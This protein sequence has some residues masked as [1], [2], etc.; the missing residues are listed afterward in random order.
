MLVIPLR[1]TEALPAPDTFAALNEPPSTPSSSRSGSV[2][3]DSGVGLRRSSRNR[4]FSRSRSVSQAP[5]LKEED[6]KSAGSHSAASPGLSTKVRNYPVPAPFEGAAP[7]YGSHTRNYDRDV[8][9]VWDAVAG[10]RR[11]VVVCGAGISV[12]SPANI[13]DFRS[14]TGLFRKLKEKHPNAGLSSGKD[15]FD[16]RLFGSEATSALFY[17]MIHELKQLADAAK[18]TSFH[19]LLKRLDVEGRLMRVYTQNID[20]LEERAGLSFGLGET[21][22]STA[23]IRALGKRKREEQK[24]LSSLQGVSTEPRLPKGRGA[25]GR[26]VSDSALLRSRAQEQSDEPV[27]MF[28]RTIPLHG[29]LSSLS[30]SICPHEL[31]LTAPTEHSTSRQASPTSEQ[32]TER[33]RALKLLAGGEPVPC[34]RCEDYENVRAVAGLRSRGVGRMKVGVVLYGGQNEGAEQV[35]E[36]LQRDILG[37]RDPHETPVPE[38]VSERRARQRK[39]AKMQGHTGPKNDPLAS[40]ASTTLEPIVEI[41]GEDALAAAFAE[42]DSAAG[43][44]PSMAVPDPP[45]TAP[46]TPSLQAGSKKRA[47]APRLKP[48]PPDLLIVAG[49]SL[50]VPGTKRI[51]REFAKACRARDHRVYNDS[52]EEESGSGSSGS[53]SR[54]SSSSPGDDEE[55]HD[56]NAPIRTILLNYD[57]PGPSREWEDIFDVWVQGD[58]QQAALGLWEASTYPTTEQHTISMAPGSAEPDLAQHSWAGLREYLESERKRDRLEKRQEAK[59]KASSNAADGEQSVQTS[60]PRRVSKAQQAKAKVSASAVKSAPVD[61]MCASAAQIL[62]VAIEQK[63]KLKKAR[64]DGPG[65][66]DAASDEKARANPTKTRKAHTQARMCHSPTASSE[67]SSAEL[68]GQSKGSSRRAFARSS[69]N[70]TAGAAMAGTTRKRRSKSISQAATKPITASFVGTKPKMSTVQGKKGGK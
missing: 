61:A 7:S 52:D 19:H 57:F 58:V 48:L 36:C 3:A 31:A 42:D 10:A 70:P 8:A 69:S 67:T 45:S 51:V 38:S 13:P 53:D 28:P 46:Q 12:S 63:I 66:G 56:P 15:L 35:G 60:S 22:D 9:R 17:S 59:A 27:P 23:T 50:K 1:P 16:A 34:S 20:N 49:T 25:W 5:T 24:C 6:V 62:E 2:V 65:P 33:L 64:G 44:T 21:G 43:Q 40:Q 47:R 41:S 4:T 39:E 32:E 55:N 68:S 11:V 26:T 29:S 37:L 18:P 30:C 54:A 14:A